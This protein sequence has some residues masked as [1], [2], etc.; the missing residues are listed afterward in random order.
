MKYLHTQAQVLDSVFWNKST[1][2]FIPLLA[3]ALI[4]TPRVERLPQ[5]GYV[6]PANGCLDRHPIYSRI[7]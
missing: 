4:T 6:P 3:V 5:P 7:N 1:T 2:F